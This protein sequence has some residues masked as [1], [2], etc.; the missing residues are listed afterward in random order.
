MVWIV[1]Y[2]KIKTDDNIELTAKFEFET[3]DKIKTDSLDIGLKFDVLNQ[4]AAE[5]NGRILNGSL[6]VREA[7]TYL[8]VI[9]GLLIAIEVSF[10]IIE[11]RRISR[12]NK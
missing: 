12:N 10:F 11:K 4:E 9:I 3:L 7:I 1:I 6:L 2:L 5:L 8:L